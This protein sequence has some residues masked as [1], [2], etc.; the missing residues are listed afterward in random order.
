MYICIYIH[1]NQ[2]ISIY[3]PGARGARAADARWEARGSRVWG[4][5]SFYIYF[6]YISYMFAYMYIFTYI[7]I[8]IHIYIYIYLIHKYLYKY[9]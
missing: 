1:I 6:I 7:Y 4:G 2:Y 9:V 8:Y 5:T 3:I